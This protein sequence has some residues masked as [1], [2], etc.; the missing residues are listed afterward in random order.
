M[1]PP[2]LIAM[3]EPL[4]VHVKKTY[5]SREKAQAKFNEKRLLREKIERAQDAILLKKIDIKLW[6]KELKRLR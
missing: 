5:E 6:K 4:E 3:G 1:S 2:S